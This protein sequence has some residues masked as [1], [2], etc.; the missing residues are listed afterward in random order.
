MNGFLAS[1]AFCAVVVGI[2]VVELS[3]KF[4]HVFMLASVTEL[5]EKLSLLFF[6]RFGSRLIILLSLS[7]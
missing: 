6:H 7:F 3:C 4:A 5:T 2:D 1:L